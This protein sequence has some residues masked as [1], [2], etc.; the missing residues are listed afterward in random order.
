MTPSR[1]SSS[2]RGEPPPPASLR[3]KDAF[4]SYFQ[5]TLTQCL[6]RG[7]SPEECFG[8]VWEE[9]LDRV[10]PS[11]SDQRELFGELIAWARS[12][13]VTEFSPGYSREVI[14]QTSAPL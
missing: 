7:F 8:L 11:E 3:P 12:Q 1:P 5:S 10:S 13:P 4:R 14:H 2:A 9:T 6:K